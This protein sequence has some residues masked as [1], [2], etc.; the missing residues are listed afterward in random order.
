MIR[1][2]PSPT[3]APLNPRMS[4]F[5]IPAQTCDGFDAW[6]AWLKERVREKQQK[7]S[8]RKEILVGR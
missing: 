5:E 7:L 2:K 4:I 1:E 8:K 6:I 3:F